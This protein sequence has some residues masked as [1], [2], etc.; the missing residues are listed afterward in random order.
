MR[1]IFIGSTGAIADA[2]RYV[3]KRGH[4]VIVFDN[5]REG[6][7]ELEAE[8]GITG[9]VVDLLNLQDLERFGFSKAD[10]VI[11]G[12]RY[13]SINV[14]LAAYAKHV[15]I[16]KVIVVTANRE[17]ANVLQVLGLAGD[18]IVINEVVGKAIVSSIYEVSSVALTED[19]AVL[20]LKPDTL[21][22]YVGRTIK[23]VEEDL[24]VEVLKVVSSDGT[25]INPMS[26]YIIKEGEALVVLAGRSAVERV[27]R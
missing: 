4:Q 25:A 22:D 14:A 5:I 2:V 11:I 9:A 26:D 24:E 20:V 27:M 23:E 16:P 6:V 18:V 12:H 8:L 21:R 17:L 15:G 3:A 13:D 19:L 10:V 1:Y 7:E